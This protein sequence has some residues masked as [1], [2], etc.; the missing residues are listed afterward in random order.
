MYEDKEFTEMLTVANKDGVEVPCLLNPDPEGGDADDYLVYC[1]VYKWKKTTNALLTV[2][3]TITEDRAQEYRGQGS[4]HPDDIFV[5]IAYKNIGGVS[6]PVLYKEDLS[7]YINDNGSVDYG[8]E[9]RY[10][11]DYEVDGVTYNR[12]AKYDD[13]TDGYYQIL[14][15]RIVVNNKFTVSPEEFRAAVRETTVVYD[16]WQECDSTGVPRSQAFYLLTNN[17]VDAEIE[18]LGSLFKPLANLSA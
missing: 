6:T 17:L 10:L 8:D 13:S 4:S 2:Y 18:D 12:W 16:K 1:G 5:E 7:I 15:D 9:F 14:T 11:D 3:Y